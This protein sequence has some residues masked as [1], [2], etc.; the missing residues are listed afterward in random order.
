M[1]LACCLLFSIQGLCHHAPKLSHFYSSGPFAK[2]LSM[3][4]FG[5]PADI[6][7]AMGIKNST[8]TFTQSWGSTQG[9]LVRVEVLVLFSALICILVELFGSRRRWYSQEFFRFFVWAVYTLFTVLAPYTIGLLQDSPFRDQT[10]VLWATILLLI[11][12]DVDSISVYSIHDIE[13][14]KRMFVQHLL[15]IILVLWLIVNCKGHNIS[16]TANIWI[17]WIQSVILTYRNYQSLSNASKKGGLLKLSKVVAD[18]MMIEHEQIPQ[19]LNPNPGTMEGYKYIFHGEEEVASLLPTAPEYTEATRRKCTTIDSVCQWIR[20]ESALNQEAKETL[21]DVALSF[22]LFKLLKRRLCGYQIGEAGLAK[23]LDFVLHGLI[24][25]EGNYIR[26]FGVIEMELSFM[27]DF[28]YTRFN[29]EHTVA[30][31]FTAWFI[32]IIVTI[33]NSISGAF[34]RH[35][36]R[37]SLEQRVHGI[38]V[39]RWVTIVLFIIVLAWYLPLRGYPDWR[40]YMVHELHVH[41][42]QRP[43]RMLILTKTSFVKDDAK[44]SWQRALGQHSLLLNFDYRPSNVLS[45]LSLGLVDATREGQKAGEKIKLTDEL[46]ERVLSGFKES[47]GQLQDGQSALAK[48][49][50][51]SQFSWACTL[52]THIDKILV[53]HIGTTIA[54]DGHPVPPTGDHRVAKTLSDYCAYLVAFVPDMLPGHGY[55]TQCIF[56]A[57]VA[58]A[59]ESITG[60]DSI[61]SRCEK[62]VMAVLPSNTSCTT[63]ELGARLGRELRGVVPEER[64]WK[65]LAD[66]WA[67]FILFLAPSSNVEIHTEMLATG[68]EFM[69]H[70]WALL[71][72]AG[73]LERPSTTDGA[74]G[75]NGAPAHDL[76][77]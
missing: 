14:R 61:S 16:Y 7:E 38:D 1:M 44:R 31:G 69:T 20:R 51:E 39:T 53:W 76:P 21:K 2:A 25:E 71:T 68:G 58:E 13:H 62:L 60:C 6:G 15:Q 10:F 18:Y 32:V 30:K 24:S 27:Y 56:D 9:Q 45:L 77:V 11:Q 41:Q 35:Y 59:W 23:T 70:L 48:N 46:I 5:V 37:S 54:M 29:T 75:N 3:D 28:L 64:R 17:F 57:V 74:Q 67:E 55:D 36:H 40:W 12:V 43:T 66:F 49:Q 22:S 19:G 47:K 26:A 33:S 52:S 34:S 42:R 50:L 65:V 73:I 8:T 72:H 4:K 63:L